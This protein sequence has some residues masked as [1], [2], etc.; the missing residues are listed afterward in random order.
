M[1]IKLIWIFK[2]IRQELEHLLEPKGNIFILVAQHSYEEGI[3]MF[4]TD[5]NVTT[6]SLINS[7]RPPFCRIASVICHSSS[8]AKE[9]LS[10]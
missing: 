3:L 7:V 8:R 4:E 9:A 2:A 1:C 10:T 6:S 5:T